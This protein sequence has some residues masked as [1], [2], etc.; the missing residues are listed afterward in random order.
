MTNIATPSLWRF[1]ACDG[2]IQT[3]RPIIRQD[4]NPPLRGP[5]LP[6][7]FRSL[8]LP[9]SPLALA[10]MFLLHIDIA[11]SVPEVPSHDPSA[12]P[13]YSSCSEEEM[14]GTG[15]RCEGGNGHTTTMRVS[16]FRPYLAGNI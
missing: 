3:F 4:S 12:L 8:R 13:S 1:R 2:T 14:L 11:L 10:L 16:R 9:D 5:F 6:L 15:I 7:A